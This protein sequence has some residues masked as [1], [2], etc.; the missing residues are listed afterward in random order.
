M[1]GFLKKKLN[2][3]LSE[4]G[5]ADAS[6]ILK[7]LGGAENIDQVSACITRLRVSL[8]DLNVVDVPALKHL[9]AVDAVKVGSTIQAIFG[10]KSAEY[11]EE[12]KQ[13][14]AK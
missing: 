13:L 7:A 1:F 5:K 10:T 14:L 4:Q 3:E 9:G 6:L 12:L 11:A 2:V 8:K